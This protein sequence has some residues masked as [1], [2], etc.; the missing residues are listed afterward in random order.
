MKAAILGVTGYTGQVLARLLASHP[1][2]QQIIPVSSSAAGK[3]MALVDAGLAPLQNTGK[4]EITSGKAVTLDEA[5][6][7]EPEIVFSALPHLKSAELCGQFAGKSLVIDLS[8]DFRI[9]DPQLFEKAY[10]EPHPNPELQKDAVFGLCEWHKESIEKAGLIANPGCYPTA[11][12]LPLLPLLKEKLIEPDFLVI[13]ALSGISGAGKKAKVPNIFTERSENMCAYAPGMTH[14]HSHEIQKEIDFVTGS[15]ALSF[16]PHLIPLKRGMFVTT[17]APL[18]GT[19]EQVEACFQEYYG[20]SPCIQ[21]RGSAIP[22]TREVRGSNR[23]DIAWHAEGSRIIL[24]SV[25]DNL[26]KGA[27][28]QAVQNMNLAKGWPEEL[29]LPLLGEV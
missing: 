5:Q 23:C 22:E 11:S 3:E 4:L 13:N 14:R 28:G 21:L 17:S 24:M 8:A 2:I 12:L 18:K 9:E 16:T 1:E 25:I 15:S 6:A 19:L 26:M 10:G 29:G 20:K 27:S 7:L